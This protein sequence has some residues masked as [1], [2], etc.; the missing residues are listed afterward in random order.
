LTLQDFRQLKIEEYALNNKR[1]K[2]C[3]EHIY[4]DDHDDNFSA[5]HV[6]KYYESGRPI[7]WIDYL[8]ID[9]RADSLL[10]LLQQRLPEM[11]FNKEVFNLTIITNDLER[12]RTLQFDNKN[13]INQV[14]ARLEYNLTKAFMRYSIGQRFGFVNP[15]YVLNHF[16]ASETD[17]T[18]Q[19]LAYHHLFDVKMEHPTKAFFEQSLKKLGTPNTLCQYLDDV[20]PTSDQYTQLLQ[21]LPSAK[22]DQRRK[23]LVNMERCRWHDIQKVEPD[24]KYIVVNVP[25]FHLWAVSPDTLIDMRVVC[26]AVKTKTPLLNSK[27]THMDINPEWIIPLSIISNDVA[28]HTG[29]SAYFAR[30]HYYIVDRKSGQ[31][32]SPRRV[33]MGMLLKGRYRVVQEGGAGNSLG[34]IIFRFPNN[35][36][37]FLHDTSSPGA[38][39][40]DNRG[41]SHGCVRLQR[42]FDLAAFLMEEPDEWLLDKLRIS[43]GMKPET[44]QGQEFIDELDPAEPTPSLVSSLQVNPHIPLYIKYHTIFLTPEGSLQYYPDVYG[45]DVAIGEALNPLLVE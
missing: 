21:L 39:G 19:A 42:P 13:S 1:I 43:M 15:D 26:G 27:I 29:D 31:R 2:Q 17:S 22:G 8:G 9:N 14:A 45:Y 36:S 28:R 33:T 23:I 7:L 38:F 6:R 24:S 10:A 44:E 16:D 34:R 41:V 25:A 37:V 11:G 5:T 12:L 18:G 35:F 40:R 32:I 4:C 20:L 30:H 3:L